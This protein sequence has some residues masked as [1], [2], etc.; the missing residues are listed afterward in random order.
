MFL[1]LGIGAWSASIFHFMIHAFFKALLFLAAGVVIMC[2]HHE[3]DMFKMG[4]LKNKLPI[5]YWTFLIGAASLAAIPLVTAGFYSK[6]QIL[7][8]TWAGENGNMGFFVAALL[9]AFITSIYTTRMM[10]LTFYGEA[11]TALSHHPGTRMTVPLILLSALAIIGGFI[12]LPHT[13]GHVTFFSDFLAPVL[14]DT[15]IRNGAGSVE[16]IVQL[17]AAVV[18]LSGVFLAYA[19][20]GQRPIITDPIKQAIPRLH[21]FWLNGWGFDEVYNVLFVKPFVWLSNINRHD[22]IDGLYNGLAS[23]TIWFHDVFVRTQNGV[24]RWYI[25]GIVVGALMIMTLSLLL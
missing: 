23:L 18:S 1:A 25:A 10:L 11:K 22:F 3:H 24:L 15:L 6:D 20:Y 19:I 8:L 5:I 4:G 9:G 7:W 17:V 14:P 13:F 2:L 12:E 16:W 21:Q